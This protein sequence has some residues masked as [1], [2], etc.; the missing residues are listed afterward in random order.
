MEHG[1]TDEEIQRING[2]EG[3]TDDELYEEDL[4][5]MCGERGV[6]RSYK[7]DYVPDEHW[8]SGAI[9][10]N[11]AYVHEK[12]I[13]DFVCWAL[14][15]SMYWSQW[16]KLSEDNVNPSEGFNDWTFN[17]KRRSWACVIDNWT[18]KGALASGDKSTWNVDWARLPNGWESGCA[19]KFI[20]LLM[21]FGKLK[22]VSKLIKFRE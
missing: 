19:K 20:D 16:S 5:M 10:F 21:H 7:I 1:F 4:C 9:S 18:C 2:Q 14:D 11:E 15:R 17:F 13:E 8:L 22:I 3:M 12:C 6:C